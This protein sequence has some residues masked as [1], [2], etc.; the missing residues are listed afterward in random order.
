VPAV[1]PGIDELSVAC[2]INQ[3]CQWLK[4]NKWVGR[5]DSPT[6]CGEVAVKLHRGVQEYYEGGGACL[7]LVLRGRSL[8]V[9]CAAFKV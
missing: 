4:N 2:P 9:D 5:A 7:T 3:S 6:H 8:L 1:L